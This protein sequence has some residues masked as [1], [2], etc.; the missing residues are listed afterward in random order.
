MA[1]SSS[2]SEGQAV[3]VHGTCQDVTEQRSV[4]DA[5]RN[6]EQLFRRAFDDAPIGMALIDL[7]GRWLRLNRSIAQMFGRTESEMRAATLESFNHPD[8]VELDRP[9]I[10]ELLAGRRRSYALEKRFVH[11]DGRVLHVLAHVSLMHGDG[12]RP[13]TSWSSWWTS[14]SVAGPRPSGAPASSACRP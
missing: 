10:R 7:E 5:L 8:D 11:A 1:R 3:V 13:C 4:E 12:E 2:T 14:V 9:L 6:A